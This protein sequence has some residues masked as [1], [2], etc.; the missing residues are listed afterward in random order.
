MRSFKDKFPNISDDK[1]LIKK[2]LWER[3]QDERIKLIESL[4]TM[5]LVKKM[6]KMLDDGDDDLGS[7]FDF[8]GWDQGGIV[9]DPPIAGARLEF[10]RADGSIAIGETDE[11]GRFTLPPLFYSGFIIAKGGIDTV[12]GLEFKGEMRADLN[13]FL[14]YPAITPLN[15]I[16]NK[17][18]EKTPTLYPEEAIDL[19][20]K[21]MNDLVDFDL[22]KI[23]GSLLGEDPIKSTLLGKEGSKE[24]QA[25]NTLI[26]IF[27]DIIGNT[28]ANNE[29]EITKCKNEVY[30]HISDQLLKKINGEDIGNLIDITHYNLKENHLECC[31]TL[32][33]NAK[34]NLIKCISDDCEKTTKEIQSVNLAIKSEWSKKA[35]DM[36]FDPEC[37]ITSIWKSIKSK[38]NDSLKDQINLEKILI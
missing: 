13:F 38:K 2:K 4:R 17:I 35:F 30:S 1:L 27:S 19:T 25:V 33:E 28:N 29:G 3:E 22:S 37:S 34:K 8:P 12:N 23:N 9:S 26:E 24:L 18:W 16:A 11:N 15:H 21:H 36:T 14:Y 10:Y 20:L 7:Y 6:R 32:I 31:E 5:D